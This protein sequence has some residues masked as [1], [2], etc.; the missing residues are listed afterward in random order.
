MKIVSKI[1]FG[2][3]IF[4]VFQSNKRHSLL[5]LNTGVSF[6]P[7]VQVKKHAEQKFPKQY[8]L[9]EMLH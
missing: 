6:L 9:V 2:K 7:D 5:L 4:G 8:S 1:D 3:K